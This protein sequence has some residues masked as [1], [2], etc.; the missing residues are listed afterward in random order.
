MDTLRNAK[1]GG[2]ISPELMRDM[3][4]FRKSGKLK[5]REELNV[6][7]VEFI[8]AHNSSNNDDKGAKHGDGVWQVYFDD[9]TV[10][11]FD[12]IWCA[13]GTKLDVNADPLFSDVRHLIS[14][15]KNGGKE[16]AHLFLLLKL[17]CL[18]P[19]ACR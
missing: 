5:L 8:P 2:T 14:T 12:A 6:E 9:A 17:D 10:E 3:K 11:D 18:E 16:S 1:G 13:T 19:F 15:P 7:T 4:E